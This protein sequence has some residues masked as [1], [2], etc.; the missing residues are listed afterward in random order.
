MGGFWILEYAEMDERG[1]P[2]SDW[3]IVQLGMP[4][5]P[6]SWESGMTDDLGLALD[7]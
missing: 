2:R 4:R 6:C 1:W 7:A 3:E 5:V